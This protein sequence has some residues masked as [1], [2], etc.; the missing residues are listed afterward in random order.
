MRVVIRPE[1][2]AGRRMTCLNGWRKKFRRAPYADGSAVQITYQDYNGA[3]QIAKTRAANEWA[4]IETALSKM[5]LHL[6]ASDQRG[7]QGHAIFDPKGTNEFIRS[8][9]EKIGWQTNI[10]IPERFSFLGTDVDLGKNNVIVEVQFS[11]YPFLLNN[12]IRSELFYRTGKSS[13]GRNIDM[14]VIITKGRMF[15][16]SNST[17]YYE[18]AKNQLDSL[19]KYKVFSVPMRLVG[20]FETPVSGAKALW[21][22]Y[23]AKR[24]SRTVVSR[25]Q[26]KCDIIAGRN[27][28]GRCRIRLGQQ[29]LG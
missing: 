16:S 18:Q 6:K 9:L 13:L 19:S 12:V 28:N 14:V 8:Q 11:N 23:S 21:T 22:K 2:T 29:K 20:L 17:L 26:I 10:P 5:Q 4:E 3:D 25:K 27:P 15:P 24:Y 7:I 1:V